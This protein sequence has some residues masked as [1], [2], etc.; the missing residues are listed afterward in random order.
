[1]GA[2]AVR[3]G[4]CSCW[5]WWR[6]GTRCRAGQAGGLRGEHMQLVD[7]MVTVGVRQSL[8]AYRNGNCKE[9][10]REVLRRVTLAPSPSPAATPDVW[11]VLLP[12]PL[13]VVKQENLAL[14]LAASRVAVD[15]KER[16]VGSGVGVALQMH[17]TVVIGPGGV[18]VIVTD[19]PG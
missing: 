3:E 19:K 18:R 2:G 14:A 4:F 8:S 15:K 9:V 6:K 7:A 5:R 11:H 16:G 12:P 1:M 10:L 13:L 17:V